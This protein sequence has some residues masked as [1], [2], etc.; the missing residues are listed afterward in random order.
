MQ[1]VV[2]QPALLTLQVIPLSFAARP[3]ES[4]MSTMCESY[5]RPP[6]G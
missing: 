3:G 2:F 4:T 1:G 5:T 6:G